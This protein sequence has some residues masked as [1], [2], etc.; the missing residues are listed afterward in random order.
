M[1]RAR[2]M[3]V[4]AAAFCA[5]AG[6]SPGVAAAQSQPPPVAGALATADGKALPPGWRLTGGDAAPRLEWRSDRPVPMGDA[7]VEFR[8]GGRV[9]GV[10]KP[11]TDG[12]TF[13]LPLDERRPNGWSGLQVWSGGHRLD[14]RAHTKASSSPVKPPP[15]LPA[16]GVDPGKAAPTAPRPASTP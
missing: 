15:P 9:L 6:A 16:N 12:H 13:R 3:W 11:S 7:R 2:R 5:V 14:A 4:T 10:P 8:S 1:V